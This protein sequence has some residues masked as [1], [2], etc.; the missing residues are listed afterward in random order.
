MNYYERYMGDYQCDTAHLSLAEHGAYTLLLDVYYSTERGLPADEERLFRLCRAMTPE[1]RQAVLSVAEQFFPIGDDGLRHNA[2]ADA[3]IARAR[4]RIEAARANGKRGGRPKKTANDAAPAAEIGKDETQQKPSG[5]ADQNPVE[6]QWKPSGKAPQ[7][8]HHIKEEK[9]S[10][11]NAVLV[12][13]KADDPLPCPHQRIIALWAEQL[14]ELQKVRDWNATRARHL[15][16]RW[17]EQA[18]RRRWQSVD[19][20]IDWFRR[21][22]AYVRQSDFLMGNSPRGAGHEGWV[23]TLPWLIK[24]ENFAKVIEGNYHRAA[25]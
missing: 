9:I 4:P 10:T 8:Q 6:T 21:L 25:A 2:R 1:E 24:P 22:F 5:F 14:P 7:H 3:E 16:A 15:Q 20:G 11:A 18:K 17:R 13:S 23:C 12:A 19:E